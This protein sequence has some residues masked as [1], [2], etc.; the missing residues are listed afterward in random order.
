MLYWDLHFHSTNSDGNKTPEERISQ[1]QLLDPDN[2]CLWAMTDHD[3]YSPNFVEPAR[4]AGIR[5]IWA[6]EI[7]AHSNELDCW[8]HITCYSPTVSIDIKNR[9]DSVLIWKTLKVIEQ[10]KKLQEHG[11]PIN[12]ADF[13]LW[14]EIQGYRKIAVSNAH[15]SAYLLDESRKNIS[16]LVLN[17]LT[18]WIITTH[19]WF[20]R[21]C[22]Q[23]GGSYPNIGV[24]TVAQY[25]PEI[26]DLV[27]IAKREDSIIS[28]AH[29]NFSFNKIYKKYWFNVDPIARSHYF[30][31][32]I[33][34]ILSDLG[35][36]NYEIN[37]KTTPEQVDYL[38][39]IVQQTGGMNTFWSDNHGSNR[40]DNKH[41]IFGKQNPVL[42]HEIVKPIT[43]TLLSFI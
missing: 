31:D 41:G 12:E 35:I 15:I 21:E 29:P 34:P 32:T 16:I 23:D 37:A 25:E 33:L 19:E 9:I 18:G 13:F 6:T 3:C 24:V 42:T 1:I 7:S 22:L 28:V 2:Q 5:A 8:L 43:N 20:I 38:I 26:S 36:K 30:H 40:E 39:Q 17:D 4:I 11:F 27:E 10:I 14:V